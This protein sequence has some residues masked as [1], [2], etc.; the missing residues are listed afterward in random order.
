MRKALEVAASVKG[1]SLPSGV[2]ARVDGTPVT[3]AAYNQAIRA[4][5]TASLLPLVAD[6]SNYGACISV[7][8]ARTELAVKVAR[9]RHQVGEQAPAKSEA[10][11]NEECEQH[12]KQ[13]QASALSGLITRLQTQLQAKEVGA[14]LN[15]TELGK[16]VASTEQRLR[17]IANDP[18]ATASAYSET[19]RYTE[20]A[21][22]EILGEQQLQDAVVEKVNAKFRKHVTKG[23]VE[24]YF[25]QHKQSY[26][27]SQP[28][29][30]SIVL[31]S[32]PSK[33]TAGALAGQH[34][35]GGLQAAAKKQGLKASSTPIACGKGN[36]TGSPLFAAVCSAKLH[37]VT[38]PVSWNKAYYVFELTSVTPAKST[39]AQLT[40]V[41]ARTI[42]QSLTTDRGEIQ[43][44]QKYNEH[45]KAKL[46]AETLCATGHIVTACS[47][48]TPPDFAVLQRGVRG[49]G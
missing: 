18:A 19:P 8:K 2:L 6:P 49:K 27:V 22:R 3:E 21:V 10:E 29:S 44:Q 41:I 40:P 34:S 14:S 25:D 46:K 20:A 37:T 7:L 48:Y 42:E 1:A 47:E 28:E 9:E 4:T 17:T 33:S 12:Y 24:R 32:S 43:A 16:Q 35:S 36:E 45:A 11:L 15:Q 13:L 5:A 38:G 39:S 23:Q 31:A 30:R 26:A